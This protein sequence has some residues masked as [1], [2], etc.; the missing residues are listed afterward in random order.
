MRKLSRM[1]VAGLIALAVVLFGVAPAHAASPGQTNPE[2]TV[3]ATQVVQVSKSAKQRLYVTKIMKTVPLEGKPK[4]EKLYDMYGPIAKGRLSVP[5]AAQLHMRVIIQMYE[6]GYYIS[7]RVTRTIT[8]RQGNLRGL[9]ECKDARI[10]KYEGSAS[11]KCRQ[12]TWNTRTGKV[13]KKQDGAR[14]TAF[15]PVQD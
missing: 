1:L 7:A 11:V 6:N 13:V 15:Y 14:I 12:T 9:I 8:F 3:T 4:G 10:N 5:R 2:Q